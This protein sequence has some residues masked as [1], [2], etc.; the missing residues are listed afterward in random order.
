MIIFKGK[1]AKNNSTSNKDWK[2]KNKKYLDQLQK[3]FDAVDKIED[4][5]LRKSIITQVLKCDMILT[6][7][8][9]KEIEKYKKY[10]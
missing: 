8:A 2:E 9:Q 10:V 3:F 5:D 1:K 7:L 6:E 4:I